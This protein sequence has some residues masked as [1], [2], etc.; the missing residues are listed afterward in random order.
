M[1]YYIPGKVMG[2]DFFARIEGDDVEFIP[3]AEVEVDP[4][5]RV[6]APPLKPEWANG[7]V[8]AEK[9]RKTF[10]EAR[11]AYTRAWEK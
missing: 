7:C 11:V 8:L 5:S 6:T 2:H 3:A 1:T 4:F 9:E 10:E